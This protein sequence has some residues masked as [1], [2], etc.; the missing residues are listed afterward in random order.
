ME[1]LV[2]VRQALIEHIKRLPHSAQRD[3]IE[4]AVIR[5]GHRIADMT[6]MYDQWFNTLKKQ[7][8]DAMQV[9]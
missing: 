5:L 7:T 1:E 2:D 9:E 4:T 6:Q 8:M 3:N